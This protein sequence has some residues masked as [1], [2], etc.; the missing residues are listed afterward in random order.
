MRKKLSALAAA[1]L[2]L[3]V[4]LPSALALPPASEPV[5]EGVDVSVFQGSVDFGALRGA[6]VQAVYIRASYGVGGVDSYFRTHYENARAAGLHLGFYHYLTAV[7]EAE[8][9]AQADFFVSLLAGLD[10]DM[11]PALD[12]ELDGFGSAQADAVCA[13]FLDEVEARTGIL[14]ALYCDSDDANGLFGPS[15]ARFP[16]WVAQWGVETPQVDRNWTAW[17]GFQYTDQGLLP[18]VEGYVDRDRFTREILF[19]SDGPRPETWVDYTVRPGDTLWAIS[20]RFGTT[21]SAI[22]AENDIP[23]PSLI[24]PGQVFRIPAKYILY[25]I[26][27]GDTLWGLS[28]RFGTTVEA[29]VSLNHIQDPDLIYAGRTLTIPV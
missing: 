15:M 19:S 2:A 27:P 22:A 3:T 7:T 24:Y 10:Y 12:F 20:R 23:N 28:R 21:V 17:T 9:R 5:M 26:R 8:A 14:P 6:G 13:A 4:L 25:T 11:R 29:L 1:L 18:G 16:L